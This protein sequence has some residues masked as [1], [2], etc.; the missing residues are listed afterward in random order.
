M[1]LAD[2]RRIK[3]AEARPWE[4]IIISQHLTRAATEKT[5][6]QGNVNKN[7]LENKEGKTATEEGK[8]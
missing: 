2:P 6:V 1:V 8:H 4:A 5:E 7:E 3:I